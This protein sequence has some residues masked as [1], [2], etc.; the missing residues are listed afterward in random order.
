MHKMK[1]GYEDGELT[2]YPTQVFS[3]NNWVL[4]PNQPEEPTFI[5]HM[6][7]ICAVD[8]PVVFKAPKTSSKAESVSQGTK[9]RAKP[10]HKKLL[11]SSK[12]PFVSS[13]EATKGGSSKAPT[14]SKSGH[15]KKR[16]E[17]SSAMDSNPSQPPISTPVDT[18]MYKEDHQATCGPT[19]L[20]VT[21]EA[22][23][24]PQLS[25][26]MSAFN[27]N[28][29]IYLASFIIYFKSASGNDASVVSTA[30]V[31]PEKFAPGD[32]VPQQQGMNEETKNTSYNHLFAGIDPHVLA[33][34][35]KSVSEGLETVL[36][37]PR[38]G[39]GASSI[40][41]QHKLELKKNKVEAEV[42]LLKA[43]P[44][45]PNVGQL[46]EL[47]VKSLQTKFSKIIPAHDFSSSLPT[48]LKDLSSK[49]NE[50]T[51]E[52]KGL[53]QQVHE[54]KIEL[55]RDLKE[56]P[57]KLKDFTKTVTSLLLNVIKILNKFA[58]VLDS[59]SSKVEDQSVPSAGQADTM[60]AA[61]EKNTNQATISQ[62]FQTKAEKNA[63]KDAEEVSIESDY[64]FETTH[65][66]GS[67]VESFKKKDF[68]KFDF[69]TKDGEHVHL[70]E[71]QISAHKKIEEE[72]DAEAARCEGEMRKKELI[73]LLG[74]EVVKIYKEDDT[75]E[76]IPEFKASDLHLGEWR[77]VVKSCPNKKG[78][79]WDPLDKLNELANKKRK[80]ANDIHDFFRANKRLKSSVQYEDHLAG[81]V[82]NEPVLEELRALRDRVDVTEA[83]NAS[84]RAT[85]RTMEAVETVLR[86]HKRQ[87]RIEIERQLASVKE[88]HRQDREDFKK[89]KKF[90]TSQFGHHS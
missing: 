37:Q 33:D 82:L 69:V 4:N 55:P 79:G 68:K 13:K 63:K 20:G 75:S 5:Y 72:V 53:K 58:Q 83:D 40:A 88:S 23:A 74:P 17:S 86:N 44:S 12:Q 19:S 36:T 59:A 1:Q 28:E 3:V 8:T 42:A 66:P 47:L 50:L 22:R 41:R 70:T 84:L 67:M 35:T 7:A 54:L 60:P 10:R 39:K 89:L 16:K 2:L 25:S 85:I 43:Q 57:S 48:E 76:I 29:P 78:K 30:E 21:S 77:E 31:D 9:T 51:E 90:V 45:F 46:N 15:S 71:E 62:L 14:S 27:L 32:F 87:A 61:E 80:H 38:I 11:T 26:V 49:F 81:N 52:V 6:L 64:D 24:N 18:R 65:V 56:I 73:D 34:Q